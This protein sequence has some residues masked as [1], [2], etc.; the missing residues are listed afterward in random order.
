MTR[1]ARGAG[2]G[3]G[4][5]DCPRRLEGALPLAPAASQEDGPAR[6]LLGAQPRCCH[7]PAGPRRRLPQVLGP[8]KEETRP[9]AAAL[10]VSGPARAFAVRAQ[11][12]RL[13]SAGIWSWGAGMEFGERGG[14]ELRARGWAHGGTQVR[15]RWDLAG[16]ARARGFVR[17]GT[18]FAGAW[19]ATARQESQDRG[20]GARAS[21]ARVRG[22][23][24]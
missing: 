20:W 1:Q 22:R 12:Q 14:R 3:A 10:F 9:R 7:R 11:E 17:A 6:A 8:G 2:A 21:S 24:H 4:R 15:D 16:G 5:G 23:G 13:G 18:G 19:R